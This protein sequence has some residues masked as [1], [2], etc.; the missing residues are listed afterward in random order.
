[1]GKTVPRLCHFTLHLNTPTSDLLQGYVVK[2]KTNYDRLRV[3]LAISERSSEDQRLLSQQIP[4]RW[5]ASPGIGHRPNSLFARGGRRT[6]SIGFST[7][8]NPSTQA[9]NG[10]IGIPSTATLAVLAWGGGGRSTTQVLYD[11]RGCRSAC[12][13]PSILFICGSMIR[14]QVSDLGLVSSVSVSTVT[15]AMQWSDPKHRTLASFLRTVAIR[16]R[17]PLHSL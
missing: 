10:C 6:G 9:L 3:P 14:I 8:R 17:I 16:Q 5:T 7:R 12:Q 4:F 1:M 15:A 2:F 13:C 11:E